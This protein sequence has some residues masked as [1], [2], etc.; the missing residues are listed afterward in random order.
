YDKFNRTENLTESETNLILPTRDDT[1]VIYRYIRKKG[2]VSMCF[3]N[4]AVINGI[5]YGK[6][7]IILDVLAEHEL[8]SQ[9][10]QINSADVAVINID[11]KVDLNTSTILSRLN[12]R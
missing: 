8:I 2:A 6:T 11:K 1:A 5:N 7:R 9:T 3:E 10:K 12:K 4:M